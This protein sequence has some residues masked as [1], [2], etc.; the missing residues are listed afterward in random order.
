MRHAS[1]EPRCGIRTKACHTDS[2]RLLIRYPQRALS[3]DCPRDLTTTS[4]RYQKRFFATYKPLAPHLNPLSFFRRKAHHL[5]FARSF[6][7]ARLVSGSLNNPCSR[8]ATSVAL[9]FSPAHIHS[10]AVDSIHCTRR[11]GD[12]KLFLAGNPCRFWTYRVRICNL[13]LPS[14]SPH[15]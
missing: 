4:T 5:P 1:W 2:I 15:T 8:S 14:G 9:S 7:N 3:T 12:C 11:G 10:R 6:R 13:P